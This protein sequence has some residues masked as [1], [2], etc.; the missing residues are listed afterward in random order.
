ELQKQIVDVN[1]VRY[2]YEATKAE[3][4]IEVSHIEP[5][6]VKTDLET[7]IKEIKTKL[8]GTPNVQSLKEVELTNGPKD[9]ANY[10]D[11]AVVTAKATFERGNAKLTADVTAKINAKAEA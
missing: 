9:N 6:N 7:A 3:E 8:K 4:N 11:G 5:A 2:D 10:A 1:V